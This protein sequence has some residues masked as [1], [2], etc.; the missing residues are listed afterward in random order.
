MAQYLI[1]IY[2]TEDSYAQVTPEMWQQMAE[3][4]GRFMEQV[5]EK[6]SRIISSEA[7]QPT[8]TATSIRGDIVTDGPFVETKEALGGYYL[9]EANDLDHALDIAKLCPA[10]YGGVEVRPIMDVSA[11]M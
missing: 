1:L 2:E 11:G 8:T 6:G 9:I 7:L 10:P 3:A 4:H 5:K